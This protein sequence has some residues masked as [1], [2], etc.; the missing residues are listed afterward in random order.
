MSNHTWL[1]PLQPGYCLQY[2]GNIRWL[3]RMGKL[4]TP[5]ID[6]RRVGFQQQIIAGRFDHRSP[7]L[8]VV[9]GSEGCGSEISLPDKIVQDAHR[10]AVPVEYRSLYPRFLDNGETVSPGISGMDERRFRISPGDRQHIFEHLL[11]SLLACFARN[12][13]M[14]VQAYLANTHCPFDI[15]FD[16]LQVALGPHCS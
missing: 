11:L 10:A 6:H 9:P 7:V 3:G 4:R 8:L 14:I 13:L 16:E 1:N 15:V 2:P 5:A 12:P